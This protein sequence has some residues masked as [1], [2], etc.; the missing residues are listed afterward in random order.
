MRPITA[1]GAATVGLVTA[2]I[3]IVPPAYA[4]SYP[5]WS[6]VQQAKQNVAKQQAM[7]ANITA[8]ISGLQTSVDT[9]RTNSEKA[10]E[11]YFEAKDALATATAK[12]DDLTKQVAAAEAKAKTSQMRAGLLASH[13]AKTS[14]QDV[15]VELMLNSKDPAD[16]N[17]LLYQLGAMSKLTEQ[18]Q[19]IYAQAVTDKNSAEALTQQANVA[20]ADR[21]QLAAAA[22]TA[23]AAAQAAQANAQAAL[24]TQQQNSTVLVAQLASL[25]N[26][27]A[28]V[29]SAYLTGQAVAAAAAAAARAKAAAEAAAA[30]AAQQHGGGGGGG[31]AGGSV[32][33]PNSNRVQTAISYARAQLG[34]PYIFDGEGPVGYDCSGLTM[35]AYAYA[36]IDIGTH[37]VNNQ[38]YTAAARGQIVPYS[39]RQPGDLIFWGSGPGNF[40][41][42]GIY[43]G[44]G[45]MIAAPQP[46]ELVKQQAVWGSPYG[47]VARPSA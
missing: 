10:A 30:A 28:A 21:T 6:D 39:Q 44:G 3:G 16:A 38:W 33:A 1:F 4:V 7:V 13:L 35:K 9:A 43:I 42:I 37:S 12:V 14:G 19:G 26:T 27:S 23:L 46:G 25:K 34:K 18:S 29:E 36:G 8:L 11:T 40:Y 15:S 41:H 2:S 24:A 31:G 20:K 32:G 45:Q 5:S 47:A 22:A 17:K